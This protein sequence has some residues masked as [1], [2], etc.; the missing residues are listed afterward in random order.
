M[1]SQL[2]LRYV[3]MCL[4]A[5]WRHP[6]PGDANNPTLPCLPK[7]TTYIH[8]SMVPL[9]HPKR[10]DMGPQE[11]PPS[12]VPLLVTSGGRQWGPVQTCSLQAPTRAEIWWLLKQVR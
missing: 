2:T 5:Q 1:V 4:P 6:I 11:P 10:W 9:R 8:K 7:L 12:P 3:L